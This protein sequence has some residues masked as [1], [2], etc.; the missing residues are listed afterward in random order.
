[1]DVCVHDEYWT[2]E[3]GDE[4]LDKTAVCRVLLRLVDR[5]T[6]NGYGICLLLTRYGPHKNLRDMQQQQGGVAGD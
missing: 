1:M 2:Q 5:V 4:R 6:C 3:G